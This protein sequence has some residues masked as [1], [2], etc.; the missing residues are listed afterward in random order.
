LDLAHLGEL[1]PTLK[2]LELGGTLDMNLSAYVPY[3]TPLESR[4]NGTVATQNA[5]F[6]IVASDLLIKKVNTEIDLAGQDAQIKTMTMQVN[7]QQVSLSGKL[8]NPVE[9]NVQLLVTS[10][11]LNLDRIFPP[12]KKDKPAS[13]PAKGDGVKKKKAPPP[14]E[15]V[16]KTELPPMARKLTADIQVKADQGRYRNLQFQKLNLKALYKQGVLESYDLNFGSE[17]GQIG[18][19]GSADLRDLNRIAFAVEPDIQALDLER[20]ASVYNL[21]KLSITGPLSVKGQLQGYTGNIKELLGSL[22]GHLNIKLGPGHLKKVGKL[23]TLFGKVFS[24]ASLQNIFSGRM[25]QDLSG[26][27]IRYNI[28]NA[29]T[30]LTKGTLNNKIHLGSDAMNIDSEGTIDLV[31]ESIKT[32][33]ILEPLATVNKALEF[34]PILGKAAGDLIKIRIDAEGPLND[35]KIKTSQIKQVGTAVKSVGEGAGDFIKGIGKGI[36]KLFGK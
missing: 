35:P 29:D 10:P 5:G 11:N 32:K 3:D 17:N 7:D 15:K 13:K 19:T 14:K 31:N 26:E 30:T 18:T 22:D 20:L 23:G 21:E 6:R 16:G 2:D 12:E 4:L 28:I 27:G 1:I 34:V 33:A 24:M 36:E 25:L 9:P 8:S